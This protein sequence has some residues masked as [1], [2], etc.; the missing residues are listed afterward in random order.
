[1]IG[2]TLAAASILA[3]GIWFVE[4]NL[5]GMNRSVA[6]DDEIAEAD[7]LRVARE[8][9]RFRGQAGGYPASLDELTATAGFEHVRGMIATLEYRAAG[10]FS[11]LSW[12]FY[13]AGV[14]TANPLRTAAIAI[15]DRN[16]CGTGSFSVAEDWCGGGATVW[17]KGETRDRVA[18]DYF[19]GRSRLG[20]TLNKFVAYWNANQ[21][22]PSAGLSAGDGASLASL[23]GYA[24]NAGTC[25][26][27]FSLASIPFE[28]QDFFAPSGA[29]VSYN[30][31]S[32]RHIALAAPI[33]QRR[34]DGGIQ[35]IAVEMHY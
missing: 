12:L 18:D 14:A 28:C 13:R 16:S 1:M 23:A 3:L 35:W 32:D 17:Y 30:Y 11:D 24:G 2:A 21:A 31:L 22:F 20:Q 7:T 6:L 27:R 15:W 29:A 19:A 5:L 4:D 10:P 34:A 33:P 9:E 25:F 8:V 26:G